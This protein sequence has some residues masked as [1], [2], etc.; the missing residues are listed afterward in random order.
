VIICDEHP[1][2]KENFGDSVLYIDPNQA[3][4]KVF[5][6]IDGHVKWVREHPAEAMKLARKSYDIFA[7]RF[8]LEGELIK[9]AE[10]YEKINVNNNDTL[11]LKY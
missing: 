8:T 11:V 10:L 1:F 3:P 4:E 9:I 7:K 2:V 5:A 6:Q